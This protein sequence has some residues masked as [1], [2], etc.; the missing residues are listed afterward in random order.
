[1]NFSSQKQTIKPPLRGIFPLD[2]F[3]ECK[4]HLTSYLSCL[5]QNKSEHNKCQD[6]SKMYLK[7]RM[8][9]GESSHRPS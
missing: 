8:D 3:S 7:C 5:K 1:M 6:G 2:H 9:K 4:P